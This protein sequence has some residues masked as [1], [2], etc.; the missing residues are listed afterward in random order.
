MQGLHQLSEWQLLASPITFVP[1]ITVCSEF[2]VTI[3]QFVSLILIDTCHLN[4]GPHGM[5]H[6]S[7]K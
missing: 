5:N 1:V 3:A 2:A 6:C 7:V 4:I